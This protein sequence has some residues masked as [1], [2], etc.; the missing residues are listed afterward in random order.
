M[1]R[2]LLA[3]SLVILLCGASH[4]TEKHG[5]FII[6]V[7]T[8]GALWHSPWNT[9]LNSELR[10]CYLTANVTSFGQTLLRGHVE[11]QNALGYLA[12]PVLGY[13]TPDKKVSFSFA[14]MWLSN[15]SSL[16]SETGIVKWWSYLIPYSTKTA[17]Q[18][19]RR[20]IDFAVSFAV[21]DYVKI[22]AGYKYQSSLKKAEMW[23]T[24][25][26][27][28]FDDDIMT[29]IPTAGLAVSYPLSDMFAIGLQA[30]ALYLIPKTTDPTIHTFKQNAGFNLEPS[31]SAL[32]KDHLILQ[33]GYRYQMYWLSFEKTN[34]VM[35]AGAAGALVLNYSDPVYL[36]HVLPIWAAQSL[37]KN[38][39]NLTDI[40]HGITLAVC[41]A[42]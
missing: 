1:K 13:Q 42:I 22:F 3:C 38:R 30:G 32:I 10:D 6:G 17:L 39:F 21:H 35:L 11:Y 4:A 24:F 41:V 36:A 2:T 15:F 23:V 20:E 14:F 31:I 25:F 5:T 9:V 28:K 34:S 40:F 12:G 8:W 16:Y 7:K 33:L 27:V 18:Y 19:S 37:R 29:H 26:N